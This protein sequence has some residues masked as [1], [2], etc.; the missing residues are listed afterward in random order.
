M[1]YISND[2]S[3]RSR[4][5]KGENHCVLSQSHVWID[6]YAPSLTQSTLER[7]MLASYKLIMLHLAIEIIPSVLRMV[8]FQTSQTDETITL[9][10]T[11]LSNA[12][13]DLMLCAF[14]AWLSSWNVFLS[15][16]RTRIYVSRQSVPLI[17]ESIETSQFSSRETSNQLKYQWSLRL[18][19]MLI[20]NGIV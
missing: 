18:L 13:I 15:L 8:F 14:S 1:N 7:H 3:G 12:F 5:R 17:S 6:F 19:N 20:R 11:F 10:A 16:I 4:N 2:Y 9:Q